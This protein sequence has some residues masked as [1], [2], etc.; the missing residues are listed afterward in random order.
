MGSVLCAEN[1]G[2]VPQYRRLYTFTKRIPTQ[3]LLGKNFPV[4]WHTCNML[5]SINAMLKADFST[6]LCIRHLEMRSRLSSLTS[7]IERGQ[8][9]MVRA[10]IVPMHKCISFFWE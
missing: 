10:S 1:L 4:G 8:R 5:P 9:P 3:L 2:D 6:I 7:A